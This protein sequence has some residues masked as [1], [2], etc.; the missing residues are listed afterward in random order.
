MFQEQGPRLSVDPD[1]KAYRCH[2]V[3]LTFP[4]GLG[5]GQQSLLVS[6][7]HAPGDPIDGYAHDVRAFP[8]FFSLSCGP[9]THNGRSR[10]R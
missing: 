10:T 8:H 3:D 7:S 4:T 6:L 1:H 2:T 9:R 5:G